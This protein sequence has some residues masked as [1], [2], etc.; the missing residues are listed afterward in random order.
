MAIKFKHKV[1]KKHSEKALIKFINNTLILNNDLKTD[2][3]RKFKIQIDEGDKKKKKSYLEYFSA[4]DPPEEM[5]EKL[6]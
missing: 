4:I 1:S 3:I 5:K 2:A 6:T